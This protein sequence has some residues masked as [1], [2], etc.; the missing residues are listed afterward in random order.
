MDPEVELLE[1]L[2][3]RPPGRVLEDDALGA[4]EMM[5]SEPAGPDGLRSADWPLSRMSSGLADSQQETI[6]CSSSPETKSFGTES[7]MNPKGAPC[8]QPV[9]PVK[10]SW[11]LVAARQASSRKRAVV[12][13]PSAQ[14]VPRTAMRG[15]PT[16]R[17]RPLQ[18]CRSRRRAVR[19]TSRIVTPL[20]SAA[21]ANGVVGEELVESVD[22]GHAGVDR[23]EEQGRRPGVTRPP[24]VAM[25]T[26]QK[27]GFTARLS[28]AA[29]IEA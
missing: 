28:S 8:I 12:R 25:P 15:A 29:A 14:S 19:R 17:I 18:K 26:M 11:C 16:V 2:V 27:S 20:R 5:N 24:E 1:V 13:L 22:D 3:V 9:R 6:A 4:A 7:K 21:A 23:L 10:T